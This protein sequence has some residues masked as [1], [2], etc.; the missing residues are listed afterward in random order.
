MILP[1][2]YLMLTLVPRFADLVVPRY[3]LRIISRSPVGKALF[4]VKF[5]LANKQLN[6]AVGDA[7]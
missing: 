6:T 7:G 4:E 1:C 5:P 2:L 3:G